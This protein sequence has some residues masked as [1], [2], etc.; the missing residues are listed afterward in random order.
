MAH[1]SVVKQIGVSE[2]GK[3]GFSDGGKKR[4]AIDMESSQFAFVVNGLLPLGIGTKNSILASSMPFCLY[5]FVRNFTSAEPSHLR[6]DNSNA[7][8]LRSGYEARTDAE[9]PVLFRWFDLPCPLPVAKHLMIIL[10]SRE[11]LLLECKSD[12]EKSAVP[13]EEWSLVS[14][15]ALNEVIVPPMPPITIY[16]NALGIEHGGNG[17]PIDEKEYRSAVEY[18][19]QH[20]T[21]R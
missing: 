3:K 16:R 20:A 5:L 19:E 9:L 12:E 7:Q 18:W 15:I 14:V 11:Q 10:Y 17:V 4:P 2:F 6:I 8:W 13:D 21:V 1:N